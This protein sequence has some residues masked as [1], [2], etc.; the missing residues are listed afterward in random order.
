MLS[1]LVGDGAVGKS[2][3]R[4]AQALALATGR[5]LTGE[6]VH[7]RAHVLYLSLEDDEEE[8]RRRLKAA[9]LHHK[10]SDAELTGGWLWL[11][12]P[13]GLKLATADRK[14]N[15]TIGGLS[16]RLIEAIRKRGIDAVIVD[17]L[18]K[19]HGVPENDNNALDRI[20]DLLTSIA[21]AE[22]VA[23]D[24]PHHTRKGASDPGN[25]DSGRGA[26]A[27]KDA[28]RLVYTLTP[29]SAEE[30]RML[31]LEPSEWPYLVRMDKAKVNLAPPADQTTWFKLV[32]VAIGNATADYPNGDEVQTVEPW[33]PPDVWAGL[34]PVV[35]KA[36]LT[37]IDQGLPD[38]R[39]YSDHHLVEE[40]CQAWRVVVRHVPGKSEAAAKRVIKQWVK[41]SLL[42]VQSYT[43]PVSRKERNG[44]FVD[45]EKGVS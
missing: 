23:V 41:N 19:A 26:S 43:N 34:T 6:Y 7:H 25:A 40:E 37:E 30:G 38:G 5:P 35:I 10:V 18:V 9:V 13:R 45:P 29:M 3:L 2:A 15:V 44:L 27:Y 1:S 14:G 32:G 4:L 42:V 39:R 8:L 33:Y 11:A 21:I 31:G 36:I 16:G 20:A 24:C 17:P 28:A 12:T 22:N